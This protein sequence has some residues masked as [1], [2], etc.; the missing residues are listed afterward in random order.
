MCR[1]NHL[2]KNFG[3]LT[4]IVLAAGVSNISGQEM[5]RVEGAEVA[6]GAGV[7]SSY[8]DLDSDGTPLAI[9]LA[10]SAEGL[11][12]PP[13]GHSNERH[14]NDRDGD[15]QVDKATECL[16][17]HDFVVPLP[18]QLVERDDLPFKWVLLNWNPMGHIPPGIYDAPHFDV[19]FMI[20]PQESIYDIKV[21]PCGP[22][23][24]QCDQFE[25][26]RKPVPANYMHADFQDV[27]AVVPAMGNHLIDVTGSEFAGEPFTRSWIYGAYDGRITFYEEMLTLDYLLSKPDV[28]NS[29]KR[30]PDVATTGYYPT[31]SCIGYDEER[32]TFTVSI[33][34]FEHREGKPPLAAE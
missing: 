3:L 27:E 14:C 33:E 31:V 17:T 5:T 9:G 21:G 25:I 18:D 1:F 23:F 20:E 19:H 22:E 34:Q 29:I 8:V 26:A 28:C 30:T 6:F 11:V 12:E 10:F 2:K 4:C 13:E 24:V 7:A 15:G 32:D 16:M